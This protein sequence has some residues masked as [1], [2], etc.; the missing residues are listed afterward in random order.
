M[1]FSIPQ[2]AS[3]RQ[4]QA[5]TGRKN[6]GRFKAYTTGSSPDP[7][8]GCVLCVIAGLGNES[9]SKCGSL[10]ERLALLARYWY[11]NFRAFS[12]LHGVEYL[13]VSA[14]GWEMCASGLSAVIRSP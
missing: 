1:G 9:G 13:A 12:Y 8:V 4:S 14:S 2:T 6:D 3:D 10:N 7:N 11:P 5:C